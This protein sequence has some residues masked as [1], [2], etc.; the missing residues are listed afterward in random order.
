MLLPLWRRCQGETAAF[1]VPRSCT[2]C[3][4][5]RSAGAF[6][7]RD[8]VGRRWRAGGVV[9]DSTLRPERYRRRRCSLGLH[10]NERVQYSPHLGT[11]PRCEPDEVGVA[12]F[13]DQAQAAVTPVLKLPAR[14]DVPSQIRG[15]I[16]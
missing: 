4:L 13:R 12:Q 7:W 6:K 3:A 10:R 1:P 16:R 11:R 15:G 2:R 8:F 14:S 5:S 9:D